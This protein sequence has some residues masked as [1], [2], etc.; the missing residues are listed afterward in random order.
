MHSF[1]YVLIRRVHE[2]LVEKDDRSPDKNSKWSTSEAM[3]HTNLQETGT[4]RK[5]LW[6]KIQNAIV[7]ILSEII[8]F[9]DRDENLELLHSGNLWLRKL[10]LQHFQDNKLTELHF[11]S[12]LTEEGVIRS[13]VPVTSSGRDSHVFQCLLPFSWLIKE[14]VDCMRVHAKGLAGMLA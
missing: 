8:A 14:K 4:Y 3:E 13:Q 5:A 12:F 6:R 7:P 10:W 11:E 1:P 9:I 2:L